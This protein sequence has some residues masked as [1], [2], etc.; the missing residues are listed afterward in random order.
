MRIVGAIKIII[1]MQKCV[2][3]F[4]LSPFVPHMDIIMTADIHFKDTWNER[5]GVYSDYVGGAVWRWEN[6]KYFKWDREK[7]FF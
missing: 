5:C 6:E 7:F 3:T 2:H 1:M 4:S